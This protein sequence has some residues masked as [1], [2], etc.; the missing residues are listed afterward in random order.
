MGGVLIEH[1]RKHV[2]FRFVPMFFEPDGSFPNHDADPTRPECVREL[3]KRVLAERA[4]MG[5]GFDG[6]AD[7]CSFID[8]KGE[9]ISGSELGALISTK[10]L[11][12][13]PGAKIA[14]C[15]VSSWIARD[16]VIEHGGQPVITPVGGANIKPIMKRQGVIFT[17]ERSGHFYL[18]ANNLADSGL[19]AA[20]MVLEILSERGGSL[21]DLIK[22]YRRY[23]MAPELSLML[24]TK[25][26]TAAELAKIK[27]RKIAKVEKLAKG[28][29]LIRCG[30]DRYEFDG[31]WFCV[32]G[33]GTEPRK[34]RVACEATSKKLLREKFGEIK[35][36][37]KD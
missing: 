2:P 17:S 16:A 37:L 28:A 12:Q 9:R 25:N 10:L 27:A 13:K 7:R 30:A 14:Y 15:L 20:L 11:E 22:P 31:W 33:S 21:S 34:L 8:E 19:I 24:G 1:L 5:L 6:D 36:L 29:R 3:R 35:R 26:S 32:R 23:Y 18:A 4:D